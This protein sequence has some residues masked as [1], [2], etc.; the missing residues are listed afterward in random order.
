MRLVKN[1]LR[2]STAIV[3]ALTSIPALAA[4]GRIPIPFT[5]PVAT[6]INITA[7]GK[8]ILTRP[9]KATAAGPLINI[10]VGVGAG[11]SEVDIDLNG[12]TIDATTFAGAIGI[13]GSSIPGS[14]GEI[15]IRNGAI[16]G[17]VN[18]I[19]I[20]AAAGAA[21]RKVA[22]EGVRIGGTSSN[23][24]QISDAQNSVLRN[25]IIVD[26][27]VGAG[28][29]AAGILLTVAGGG[30]TMQATIEN[31]LVRN[32]KDGI[33]VTGTAALPITAAILNNR[34]E[35]I[36][37]GGVTGDAIHLENDLGCLVSENT[38]RE[39]FGGNGIRL[40]NASGTKLFDNVV[41]RVTANGIFLDPASNDNLIWRNV[42]QTA[43]GSGVYVAGKRN[44]IDANLLNTNGRD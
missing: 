27:G 39:V 36:Q 34:L 15:A 4:E 30:V 10:A 25:N 29:P 2:L 11:L 1:H 28:G 18:G 43:T 23:A 26:A 35:S 19:V 40:V 3:L 38:I 7:P 13:R 14:T 21:L 9:L 20:V 17:G 41:N 8:Y 42:V 5:S 12:F 24:L 22:V 31:N 6:P 44:E 37:P 16:Q 33:N 32:T